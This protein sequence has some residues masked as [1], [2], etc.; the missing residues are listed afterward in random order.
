[1]VLSFLSSCDFIR[2]VVLG[3][4]VLLLSFHPVRALILDALSIDVIRVK[5]LK[6]AGKYLQSCIIIFNNF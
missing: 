4:S 1:M 3:Y 6:K 2:I 5:D